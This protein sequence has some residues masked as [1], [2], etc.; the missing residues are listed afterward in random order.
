MNFTRTLK[1]SRLS[2]SLIWNF[3]MTCCSF[4]RVKTTWLQ[5]QASGVDLVVIR[6]VSTSADH[7]FARHSSHCQSL[8]KF[9]TGR[10]LYHIRVG[11]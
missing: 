8:F 7:R 6:W 3:E 4:G 9:I 2:V 1:Y 11:L 10:F 5:E